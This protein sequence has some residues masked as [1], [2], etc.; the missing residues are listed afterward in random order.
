MAHDASRDH[1]SG[2]QADPVVSDEVHVH[3]K[4]CQI[5]GSGQPGIRLTGDRVD[6]TK[7]RFML[8]FFYSCYHTPLTIPGLHLHHSPDSPV[9][10][11][12][13]FSMG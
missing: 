6:G 12:R 1:Q 2:G 10:V 5:G 3:R 4:I 13:A 9:G 11:L 7:A 8:R